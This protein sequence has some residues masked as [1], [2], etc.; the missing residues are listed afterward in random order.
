MPLPNGP[1]TG[2]SFVTQ[3]IDLLYTLCYNSTMLKTYRYRLYPTKEQETALRFTLE[4]CRWLYNYLLEQRQLAYGECDVSLSCFDQQNKF[5]QLK[6]DRPSLTRVHSQ[7]M[8][9]VSVR[10][11]LAFKSFFRRIKAGEKSGYPRF[12]GEGR[13]DSF[14]YPQSGFAIKGDT[15]YLSKIGL[16]PIIL[17]R[18]I[19]GTVKTCTVRQTPTDKWFVTFVCEIEPSPLPVSDKQ[20][21]IDVGLTSFATLSDGK[22]IEN[23]HFYRKEE[24]NLRRAQQRKEKASIGSTLRQK[25]KIIVAKIH[26]R[27]ANKRKN[28]IHQESRKI[29]NAYQTI[30]VEDITVN[31]MV[32]NHCL[33]KS[34]LD[35]AWTDFVNSLM[36]KAA[37][38]NRQFV[39]INPAYTSQDCSS[40]G[41]R[42][43]MPLDIREYHCPCCGLTIDR[44]HNAALNILRVGLHTI[45]NQSVIALTLEVRE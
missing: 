37:Y 2:T 33:A 17:H 25:R 27:I 9:S 30:A 36:Y 20:V 35:A 12:R 34:I 5:P 14:T 6:K 4:E 18:P 40:C 10:I 24:T 23:P 11:D 16:V 1:D 45:S 13:Y 43:K 3:P 44:D 31:R 15:L 21:G 41:H 38:A 26:E 22:A 28:F 8:Q 39:K 42:Q 29:V 19:E 32:H 7:V